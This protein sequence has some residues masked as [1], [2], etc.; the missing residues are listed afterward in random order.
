MR[1]SNASTAAEGRG[2]RRRDAALTARAPPP[3]AVVALCPPPF[4]A[5]RYTFVG[6]GGTIPTT[7]RVVPPLLELLAIASAMASSLRLG[8]GAV[9][10]RVPVR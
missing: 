7:L 9:A 8:A 3:K 10:S 6:C 4:W 1:R 2:P 5:G